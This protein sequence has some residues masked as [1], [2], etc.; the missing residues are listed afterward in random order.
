MRMATAEGPG[1]STSN[2][3]CNGNPHIGKHLSTL[4]VANERQ[5]H[6]NLSLQ[7]GGDHHL[8]KHLIQKRISCTTLNKIL[9]PVP[10]GQQ[11]WNMCHTWLCGKSY[12]E[13]C[14]TRTTCRESRVSV[15]LT[16]QKGMPSLNDFCS[17]VHWTLSLFL[18]CYL[19]MK[20]PLPEMIKWIFTT[21]TS[22]QR[23]ILTPLFSLNIIN[24]STSVFGQVLLQTLMFGHKG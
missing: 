3:F 8:S 21:I 10:E 18:Q 12:I 6:F 19:Q 14:C 15:R 11:Q 23:K 7:T 2:V 5:E 1:A 4:T 16:F 13:S 17:N 20:Q 22:E 9:Q 24:S